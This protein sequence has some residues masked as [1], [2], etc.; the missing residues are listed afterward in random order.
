MSLWLIRTGKH[1]EYEKKF[2]DDN[3]VYLTWHELDRDLSQVGTKQELRDLLEATYPTATKAHISNH[4]GQIWAF[5]DV[6]A[7]GDWLIIPS[8][9]KPAIHV[10]EVTGLYVFDGKAEAPYFH[11]R[12]IK[13]IAKDVPRAHFDSD[14]LY[15]FGAI[16]TICQMTRNDAEKRV[17]SMAQEGWKAVGGESVIAAAQDGSVEAVNLELLARDEIAKLII[18]KFKGHGLSRLIEAIL[19]A[20]GY[21][22]HLSPAGPDKGIDIL[23]APGLLGF[24]N[25]RICVQVKSGDSP[26]DTPTLNQLI[27]AMQNVQA[28][29]GLLVS[30]GGFKSSVDKE[31]PVQFFRVRLWDQNTIIAELL[32]N[33]ERLDEDLRAELPLKRIWTIAMPDDNDE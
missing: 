6:I 31:I 28:D 12:P 13:W 1:G 10:A 26:V 20:Q 15:S 2:L 19:R 33:Y 14:L 7:P 23:A 18:S 17:R 24:G 22:T 9:N 25:P 27:G 4:L 30:W 32:A 29:Q 5:V 21:T 3:R 16:Q 8:K 11:F